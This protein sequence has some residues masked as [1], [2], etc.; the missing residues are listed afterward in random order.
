MTHV[1][2][3]AAVITDEALANEFQKLKTE[4]PPM[5]LEEARARRRGIKELRRNAVKFIKGRTASRI[6][7]QGQQACAAPQY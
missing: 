5:T 7:A 3:R 1:E 6:A 4:A 2:F